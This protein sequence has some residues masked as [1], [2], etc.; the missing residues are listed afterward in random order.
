MTPPR[1]SS[2]T[3]W[4]YRCGPE[5]LAGC[6]PAAR[7]RKPSRKVLHVNCPVKSKCRRVPRHRRLQ[8]LGPERLRKHAHGLLHTCQPNRH[9]GPRPRSTSFRGAGRAEF[10]LQSRAGRESGNRRILASN[11]PEEGIVD[12]WRKSKESAI[13]HSSMKVFHCFSRLRPRRR[14]SM[15]LRVACSVNVSDSFGMSATKG[16]IIQPSPEGMSRVSEA[17]SLWT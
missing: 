6:G 7:T 4:H 1:G 15:A 8:H 10:E 12:L 17:T 16:L 13:R 2:M 9:W 14:A 11:V 3:T 5:L